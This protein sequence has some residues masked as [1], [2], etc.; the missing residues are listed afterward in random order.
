MDGSHYEPALHHVLWELRAYLDDVVVI[1]GWVP[2]LYRKYGGFGTWSGRTSLTMEVDVLVDRPLPAGDR[3]SI[4]EILRDCGFR[5]SEGV[6]GAAVWMGDAAAGE[7]IEFL[8]PHTGTARQQGDTVPVPAQAGLRAISLPGLEL[9]RRYRRP[10]RIPVA[11]EAGQAELDVHL[12]WLGAYVVNKATTFCLRSAHAD[13]GSKRPKDLLY[14]RD[15]A[16]AGAEVMAR[17]EEDLRKMARDRRAA[18]A[19]C[20][21]ANHLRLAVDGGHAGEVQQAVAALRERDA[22]PSDAAAL[23]EFRGRLADLLDVLSA[24]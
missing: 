16:A 2:Y 6:G 23:A 18:G 1:G 8:V 7:M 14:L 20:N 10:V 13:G 3:P 15:V 12:P 5:P 9:M 17:L 21:A 19:I 22:A 24:R 4:P 11:T